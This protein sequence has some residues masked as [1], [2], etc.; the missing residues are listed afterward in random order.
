MFEYLHIEL[1]PVVLVVSML[2][3]Y[4]GLPVRESR[5]EMERE[6]RKDRS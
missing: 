6:A 1:I 2:T 3:T 5:A 4:V